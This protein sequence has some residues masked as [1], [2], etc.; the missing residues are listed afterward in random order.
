MHFLSY[1]H[2]LVDIKM[3]VQHSNLYVIIPNKH[4]FACHLSQPTPLGAQP[5]T[6]TIFVNFCV[7]LQTFVKLEKQFSYYGF[8]TC[9]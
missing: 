3:L 7:L 2:I 8:E 1:F 4:L 9:F 6:T 5:K